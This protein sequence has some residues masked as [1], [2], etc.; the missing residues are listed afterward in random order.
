MTGYSGAA[1]IET[2]HMAVSAIAQLPGQ[3]VAGGGRLGRLEFRGCLRTG[4]G[5]REHTVDDA[6]W[7]IGYVQPRA[8]DSGLMQ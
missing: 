6:A 4:V 2:C 1:T 7:G 5:R 3:R 8:V